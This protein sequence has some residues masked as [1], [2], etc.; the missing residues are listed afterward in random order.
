MNEKNSSEKLNQ[1]KK[2][3]FKNTIMET[4]LIDNERL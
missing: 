1:T 2:I 3:A 4:T